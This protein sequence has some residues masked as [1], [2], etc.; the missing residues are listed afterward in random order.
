MPCSLV[1]PVSGVEKA[2][3]MKAAA[4]SKMVV[5]MYQATQCHIPD[6]YKLQGTEL[7]KLILNFQIMY[8]FNT[9]QTALPSNLNFSYCF[10]TS[11][12]EGKLKEVQT[13]LYYIDAYIQE[14]IQ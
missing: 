14:M 4:S 3:K 2:L 1:P 11:H 10:T 8:C 5:P 9:V 7:H 13:S 12:T 6:E